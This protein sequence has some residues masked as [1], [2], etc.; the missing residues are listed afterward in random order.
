MDI[1]QLP[2]DK[3]YKTVDAQWIGIVSTEKF[4]KVQNLL[5]YNGTTCH[6]GINRKYTVK[7]RE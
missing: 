5:S 3:K 6:N 1:S 7:L 4:N 2:D